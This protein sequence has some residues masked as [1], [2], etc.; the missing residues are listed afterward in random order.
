MNRVIHLFNLTSTSITA[1]LF[2]EPA[3]NTTAPEE[4]KGQQVDKLYQADW[5]QKFCGQ[6]IL[7]WTPWVYKK[8]TWRKWRRSQRFVWEGLSLEVHVERFICKIWSLSVPL[9]RQKR[10]IALQNMPPVGIPLLKVSDFL[11]MPVSAVR[12]TIKVLMLY[13]SWV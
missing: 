2:S 3:V 12:F 11:A 6:S 5:Y 9:D 10:T 1:S 8:Y 7:Q 4:L 13:T